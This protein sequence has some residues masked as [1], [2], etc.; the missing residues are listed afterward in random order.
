MADDRFDPDVDHGDGLAPRA[1]CVEPPRDI[2][3]A[4]VTLPFFS[5]EQ[6]NQVC[7][8]LEPARVVHVDP[9]DAA[10]MAAALDEVDVALIW[11]DLDARF[12]KAPNLRWVHCDHAGL[13]KS[14]LPE[15][16]AKGLLVTGSAGRS[17]EALAQHVFYFALALTFDAY[18]LHDRQRGRRWEYPPSA[19]DRLSL[20]DKTLGI[21]GLGHTGMAVARLAKA[22]GMRVVAYR[23]RDTPAPE[24][25]ER[26][27]SAARDDPVDALLHSSDVVVLASSLSDETY[28]LIGERELG[29]MKPSAYLINIGRGALVDEAAL[30][31]A[32]AS[33]TIAGAGSDVFE[34]EPLP[35]ESPLWTARNMIVTPHATPPLPDRTQRSVDII[36]ENV[37]RYRSG[38]PLLNALEP[39]DVYTHRS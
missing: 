27:Y 37:A 16:F 11:S 7:A 33:G 23:R 39:H 20:W 22:F 35:T 28:H 8:A 32:L 30:F 18:G 2:R 34:R 9:R 24:P 6:L 38:T 10:G 12:F 36:V 3:S 15:V 13:N 4:L 5:E 19:G 14:A 31:D 25:V 26:L 29:L 17:A 1:D 21:I